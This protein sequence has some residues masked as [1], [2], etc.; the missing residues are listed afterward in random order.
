MNEWERNKYEKE[1][2]INGKKKK[3]IKREMKRII[4]RKRGGTRKV[5]FRN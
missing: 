4:H 1:A 3:Q 2:T 5:E